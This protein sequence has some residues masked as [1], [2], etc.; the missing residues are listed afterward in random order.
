MKGKILTLILVLAV[1]T[2]LFAIDAP[3][4]PEAKQIV[5]LVNN[6]AAMLEQKGA[7]A[8]MAFRAKESVWFKGETYIFVYGLD[9][10]M[11]C[12]P[13]YA[14]FEGKNMIGIKDQNGKAYLQEM[15]DTA[16]SKGSGWIDYM[17]PKPGEMTPSK[18]LGYFRTAKMPD[19]QTVLVGSGLYV[20]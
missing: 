19:G 6:A 11:L 17:L 16:K 8:F 13:P 9:G 12:N 20:K 4:S 5:D 18:K 7:D 15:I 3:Q 10:K 1:C 14:G 2:P